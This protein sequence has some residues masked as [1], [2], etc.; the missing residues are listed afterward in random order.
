MAGDRLPCAHRT[1]VI[2]AGEHGG[3]FCLDCGDPLA[4]DAPEGDTPGR[5]LLEAYIREELLLEL[6]G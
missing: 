4:D 6:G 3:E 5:R 1:T 2:V